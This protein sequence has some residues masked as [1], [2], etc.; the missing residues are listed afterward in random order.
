MLRFDAAANVTEDLG[1]A[2][3]DPDYFNKTINISPLHNIRIP[4]NESV[5]Y[6]AIFI[7][8]RYIHHIYLYKEFLSYSYYSIL[9]TN[10][11]PVP[12]AFKYIATLQ[13][14]LGKVPQQ[15]NNRMN[16]H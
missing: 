7:P 11:Y 13:H 9:E 1:A 2:A 3:T 16:D 6:P 14:K 10:T 15:V 4:A 12:L 8:G 5:Q